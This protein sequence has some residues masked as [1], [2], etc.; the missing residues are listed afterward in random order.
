MI[1]LDFDGPLVDLISLEQTISLITELHNLSDRYAVGQVQNPSQGFLDLWADLRK[2]LAK[3][4]AVQSKFDA[5]AHL[6][7]DAYECQ[8][9]KAVRAD[10]IAI[11]IIQVSYDLG[12]PVHIISN[13]SSRAIHIWLAKNGISKYIKAVVGRDV[14]VQFEFLKPAPNRILPYLASRNFEEL[15]KTGEIVLFVGDTTSDQECASQ[16]GMPFVGVRTRHTGELQKTST[17]S[18]Y[19]LTDRSLLPEFLHE[20]GVSL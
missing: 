3:N 5:E 1:M 20:L 11:D 16:L 2:G 4:P 13:N 7:I 14:G 9:A 15:E 6:V 10:E 8:A 19:W 17:N 12:A 18:E